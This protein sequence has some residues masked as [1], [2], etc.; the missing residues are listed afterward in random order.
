MIVT[1]TTRH[2]LSVIFSVRI[3]NPHCSKNKDFCFYGTWW[4]GDGYTVDILM[5][6]LLSPCSWE[7]ILYPKCWESTYPYLL[8]IGMYLSKYTE[9]HFTKQYFTFNFTLSTIA[10]QMFWILLLFKYY[11][12]LKITNWIGCVIR[13]YSLQN[14]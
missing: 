5:R 4:R 11:K 2:V 8:K 14:I 6:S 1:L 12:E 13:W 10:N 3:R 9:Y 7:I